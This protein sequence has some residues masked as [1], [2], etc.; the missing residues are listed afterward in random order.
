MTTNPSHHSS[1]AYRRET[2]PNL[3]PR[4]VWWDGGRLT[5]EDVQ[6]YYRGL[7]L[8]DPGH[9]AEATGD[10]EPVRVLG[11]L[12]LPRVSA[13]GWLDTDRAMKELT[14]TDGLLVIAEVHGEPALWVE[15]PTGRVV[16]SYGDTVNSSLTALAACLAMSDWALRLSVG[17]ATR[18]DEFGEHYAFLAHVRTS[19]AR[20]D[21]EA[22]AEHD[23]EW[24]WRQTT[25]DHC[26]SLDA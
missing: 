26:Y 5:P 8:A 7:V 18:G 15:I 9:L 14:V 20:I 6:P 23:D 21:P 22:A 17:R 13:L 25:E 16:D 11:T 3:L 24:W 19:L 1:S 10:A 2:A 12:G 4:D